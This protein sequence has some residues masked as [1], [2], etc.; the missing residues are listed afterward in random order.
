MKKIAIILTLFL[1]YACGSASDKNITPDNQNQSALIN[2][3]TEIMKTVS[4]DAEN[5]L[6]ITQSNIQIP[7]PSTDP[8]IEE[9]VDSQL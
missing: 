4:I 1:L 8:T 7:S 9:S 6:D 3:D 5:S 2:S